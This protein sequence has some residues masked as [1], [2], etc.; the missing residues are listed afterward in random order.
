M[1]FHELLQKRQSCRAYK[2]IPVE[3]EKLLTCIEAAR[4]S[5]SACNSQPWGFV[6]VD[7]PGVAK[8]IPP[9]MQSG[10]MP[11]N[12]FTQD[13]NAFIIVVEEPTNISSKLG[14]TIKNQQFAQID[15]GIASHAICLSAAEQ[16]LG[17][18]IMGYFNEKKIKG[19]FGI[20]LSKRIRLIIAIGYPTD[21]DPLRRKVRKPIEEILH[22]NKW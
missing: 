15:I 17:S 1:T 16:G 2:D 8:Q 22:L 3:R 13:C 6:V 9:L 21:T 19:L 14:S 12:R 10:I 11:I 20:P 18:C 4:L 7:D 5:P